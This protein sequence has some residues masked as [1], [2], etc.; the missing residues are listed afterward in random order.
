M[1]RKNS[2][3][4]EKSLRLFIRAGTKK[5]ETS[6]MV[7]FLRDTIGYSYKLCSKRKRGK[8]KGFFESLELSHR[9]QYTKLVQKTFIIDECDV[10]FSKFLDD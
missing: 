2:E 10:L 9:W 3:K 1:E 4:D 7:K 8:K 6:S 5:P